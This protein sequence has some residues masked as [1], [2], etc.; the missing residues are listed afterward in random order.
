VCDFEAPTF[1]LDSRITD[2]GEVVSLTHQTIPMT[3]RGGH[4]VVRRRDSH[5]LYTVGSQMVVRL[6]ILR[7]GRPLPPGRFLVLIYVRG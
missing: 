6:S 4:M 7:S 2:G 1:Y 3:G 5:I